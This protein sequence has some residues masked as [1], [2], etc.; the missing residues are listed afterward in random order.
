MELKTMS[1]SISKE[2][3]SNLPTVIYPG[4]IVVINTA[5]DAKAA[6]EHIMRFPVLGFDTETRPSFKK[7]QVHKVAL[8]QISTGDECFLFRINKFGLTDDLIDLFENKDILKIGLSLKDDYNAIQKSREFHHENFIDLQTFAKDFGIIDRSLQRM[9]A[10][11][12]NQR[13]SKGQRL[14]NW[15]AEELT[16]PQQMYAAID[17]WACLKIYN[18]LTSGEFDPENSPYIVPTESDQA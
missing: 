1:L 2:Q 10:I 15:A 8:I 18:A 6:I 14:T 9:Y 17:A 13:I 11:I 16:E 5:D 7:G 12:F 3:L 4:K